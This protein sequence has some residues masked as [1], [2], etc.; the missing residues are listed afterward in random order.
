MPWCYGMSRIAYVANATIPS[1]TANSIH[2][3]KMCEAL[4]GLGHEVELDFPIRGHDPDAKGLDAF[5]YYGVR[6]AF[7]LQQ[8]KRPPRV[9]RLYYALLAGA[10]AR[11][12]GVD[13]AYCR[14][15]WAAHYCARF[16]VSTVFEAHAPLPEDDAFGLRLFER[17]IRHP[18]FCRLVVI[19]RALAAHYES[20]F[21]VLKGRIAVLPDAASPV[22][23]DLAAVPLDE[24]TAFRVGYVGQLY[25]GKGMEVV[26]RV[27]PACPW[28]RFHI[29]GGLDADIARWKAECKEVPNVVFHGYVKH[30]EVPAYIKA[31]DAVLLPNQPFVSA[32]GSGKRNI[33]EWTSPLKAF[34]YM[35]AG[36]AIIASDL[37]ALREVLDNERNALLCDAEAPKAWCAALTRLKDEPA[38]GARLAQAARDDFEANYSWQARARRAL[39]GLS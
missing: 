38:L 13:L 37:P 30:A 8:L 27:A 34:E 15:H 33:S 36:K 26:V 1:R 28:A 3:M 14:N 35:A 17:L 29:V 23:A 5:D 32:H 6:R 16:G 2:V 10:R 22:A 25:R 20:R 18:R 4:A 7:E 12:R 39:K 19:T 9:A 31:M 24:D 11:W 21:P